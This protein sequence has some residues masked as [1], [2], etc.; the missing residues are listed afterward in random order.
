MRLELGMELI[1]AGFFLEGI[2][3]TEGGVERETGG[4]VDT[5]SFLSN[6]TTLPPLS[7]VAR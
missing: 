4:D 2:V 3:R 7:P 5:D 1:F 6:K